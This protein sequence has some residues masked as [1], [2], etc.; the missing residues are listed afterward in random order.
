MGAVV[1]L[2]ALMRADAKETEETGSVLEANKL[3]KVGAYMCV[4]TAA[5]LRGHKGFY[6]DL[7]R[8]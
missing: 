4:L 3:W 5:L 2:L 6:L 7:V 1:H 8:L